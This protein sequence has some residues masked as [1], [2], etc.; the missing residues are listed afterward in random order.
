MKRFSTI[1]TVVT[2][3]GIIA[4]AINHYSRHKEN[5]ITYDGII[6]DAGR[7]STVIMQALIYL[8][9]S[10]PETH[11]LVKRFI[12]RITWEGNPFWS[13]T[14]FPDAV[15]LSTHSLSRGRVYIASLL[16]HEL[17]HI[18]FFKVRLSSLSDDEYGAV[19]QYYGFL[20][21]IPIARIR[22]LSIYEEERL[23]HYL[24]LEFLQ[25]HGDLSGVA[26]QRVIIENLPRTYYHLR[27]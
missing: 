10:E 20:R 23:I 21:S 24:Q 18:I 8:K 1:V 19:A 7:Y 27:K 22:G 12:R 13:L 11:L 3:T 17:N 26:L 4:C 25:R 16:F 5:R 6:V 15:S 9:N 2:L 14:H